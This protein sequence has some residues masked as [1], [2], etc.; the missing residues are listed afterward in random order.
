LAHL[1]NVVFGA[2]SLARFAYQWLFQRQLATRKLPYTLVKNR[3]GSYPLEFNSE[4]TPLASSRVTLTNDVDRDGLKRVSVDWRLSEDDVKAA[5]RAFL[6]LQEVLARETACKLELDETDLLP[7]LRRSVPLGGHHLGTARMGVASRD[8]VVDRN[9]AAIE[10]PNLYIA[11]SAVFRT[12]S[13]A[14]PTLTI[15]AMAL[16]LSEHLKTNLAVAPI[17]G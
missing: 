14:N 4:Q 13:H 16:R 15:V 6:L 11:S 17:P 1:R 5:Q 8:G 2:P 9:C 12:N 3:D 7:A 10:I